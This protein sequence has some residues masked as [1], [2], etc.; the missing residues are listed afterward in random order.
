MGATGSQLWVPNGC[1]L[2]RL[3]MLAGTRTGLDRF[4]WSNRSWPPHHP[5]AGIKLPLSYTIA[6][7][8]M[9]TV[10][11]IPTYFHSSDSGIT[12]RDIRSLSTAF[13]KSLSY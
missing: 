8:C 10:V 2:S 7:Y 11:R 12:G 6:S 9:C 4:C 1:C 3:G 5:P 13:S